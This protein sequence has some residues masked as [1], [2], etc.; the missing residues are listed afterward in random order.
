MYILF[1][2]G[3]F[4]AL[5]EACLDRLLQLIIDAG[6]DLGNGPLI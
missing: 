1:S 4:I 5:A 3:N 2:I 6:I